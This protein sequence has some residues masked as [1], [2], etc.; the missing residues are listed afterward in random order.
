MERDHTY[1]IFVCPAL[2][3][4][5]RITSDFYWACGFDKKRKSMRRTVL[6]WVST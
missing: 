6:T 5:A 3:N 1:W 2:R 4:L